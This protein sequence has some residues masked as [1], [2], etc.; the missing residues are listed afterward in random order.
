[1]PEA[2]HSELLSESYFHYWGNAR[3]FS[4]HDIG[5]FARGF[6]QRY[7]NP[8]APLAQGDAADYYPTDRGL[9]AR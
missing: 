3:S 5:K 9:V 4:E 8:A 7:Q 2:V 6:Q 1:M